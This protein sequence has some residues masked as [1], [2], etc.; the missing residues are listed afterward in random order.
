MALVAS[1]IFGLV[2]LFAQ[3]HSID[4]E[5][6]LRQLRIRNILTLREGLARS[7]LNQSRTYKCASGAS[8]FPVCPT[9][10]QIIVNES[11]LKSQI[12]I[13]ISGCVVQPN[14]P[15]PP[16]CGIIIE[17]LSISYDPAAHSTKIKITYNGAEMKLASAPNTTE[18][19][20]NFLATSGT[21][22]SCSLSKP[23]LRGVSPQGSAL[24]DD[25]SPD[26]P[27][28]SPGGSPSFFDCP[29]AVSGRY[30]LAQIDSTLNPRFKP[31]C[32]LMPA[33]TVKCDPPSPGASIDDLYIDRYVWDPTNVAKPFSTICLSKLDPFLRWPL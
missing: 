18:V 31:T 20:L 29:A 22:I 21:S 17:P 8:S 15:P 7:L 19:K 28:P 13:P 1:V 16:I 27:T 33:T 24:C 32:L 25:L 4:T 23:F 2:A 6:N 10:D 3:Q 30:Y 11:F 9:G 12:E 14:A 5:K 26:I